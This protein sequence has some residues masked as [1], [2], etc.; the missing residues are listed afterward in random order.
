MSSLYDKDFAPGTR[1]LVADDDLVTRMMLTATLNDWGLEVLEA[2][3]GQGALDVLT[4]EDPPRLA[5]VDWN[6][7]GKDGLEVC[8]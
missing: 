4:S 7:P 3:D 8:R 2:E 5:L 1:V 6:M